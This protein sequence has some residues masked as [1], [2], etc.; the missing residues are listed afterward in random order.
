MK[1]LVMFANPRGT[2][3]LRLGEEDKTIQECIRR[4]KQRDNLN[5]FSHHAATVDDVRRALLDDDFQIVHF[6]GHGTRT[7]LVFEDKNGS[8]Y[9]PPR[10]A[11]AGLLA[12]FVPPLECVLLNAC[13][14]LSQGDFTSVG[15]PYTIAMEKPISDDAAIIFT[16]AFYDSIGAGKDIEFSFKQGVHALRLANHPDSSVP[17]LIRKGETVRREATTAEP[18]NTRSANDHA[19]R[20][21]LIGI[22]LDVSGS[23]ESNI[24]NQSGRAQSRIE[25]FQVALKQSL[26]RSRVVLESSR[27]AALPVY[28]FAY[29]FGL[30]AGSVGDLFSLIRAAENLM[31]Q[32]ELERLK[33]R[34]TK[35]IRARYSGSN[36]GGLESLARSYGFG[37]FVD[38]AKAQARASAESEVKNRILAEVQRRLSERLNHIGDTTLQLQ[39]LASMWQNSSASISGA[40]ALIFGSTPMREA[41]EKIHERFKKELSNYARGKEITSVLLLVS[42]GDPTDGDPEPPAQNIRSLGVTIVS[43]YITDSDVSSPR[44]L[45]ASPDDKWP[46]GA[47]RLF[48]M[49]SVIEVNSPLS[50]YLLR[51]GW[52]IEEGAKCF[53]Q[54]NHSEVLE[55]FVDF[56]LSPVEE[57]YTLLPKGV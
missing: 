40:E 21:L 53:I 23:M 31:P 32:A 44:V 12:D 14:S 30:R 28:L 55:E 4:S 43:C 42:D 41:L 19:D 26:E 13:Y 18:I 56:A 57:G 2:S 45:K 54:V 50:H 10:D 46:E 35:D 17:L 9:V 22:G 47:K 3:S 48:R 25:A 7:G 1:I 34:Y 38:S 52:T 5:I 27:G 37:G 33:A 20:S 6:S 49:S 29:A 24:R 11:L 36:L 39:D 8:L 51:Q 15:V 16:G